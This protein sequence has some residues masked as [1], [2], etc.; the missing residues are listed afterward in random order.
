MATKKNQPKQP[1]AQPIRAMV[2]LYDII[3]TFDTNKPNEQIQKEANELLEKINEVLAMHLKDTLPQIFLD[4]TKKVKISIVP[5][6]PE[7]IE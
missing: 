7:D 1:Q 2:K 5:V 3:L 4:K 6:K